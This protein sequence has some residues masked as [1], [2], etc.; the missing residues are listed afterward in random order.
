[1]RIIRR[2]LF[3]TI[4]NIFRAVSRMVFFLE[5]VHFPIMGRY[6]GLLQE[7]FVPLCMFSQRGVHLKAIF[8][9]SAEIVCS[10]MS[11][12]KSKLTAQTPSPFCIELSLRLLFRFPRNV[13]EIIMDQMY[14]FKVLTNCNIHMDQQ[15]LTDAQTAKSEL[16]FSELARINP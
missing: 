9:V 15:N 5:I 10:W 4:M 3:C 14:F 16:R 13:F 7:C 12:R 11:E 1:M 8:G 2:Q 6:F